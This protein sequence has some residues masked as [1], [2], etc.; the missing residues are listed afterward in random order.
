MQD[1]TIKLHDGRNLDFSEYGK[2][3][4]ISLLLFHGTPGSRIFNSFENATWIKKFGM[5]VITPER[6]GFGLSDPAPGRTIIDWASDVG[7]LA[8]YLGLDKFYV[9]GGSG[10]GP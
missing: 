9:A 4:G 5:H 3:D 1:N 6:P 8:D 10:G 2:E 7:E